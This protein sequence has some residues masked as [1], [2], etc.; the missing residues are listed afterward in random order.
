MPHEPYV[1]TTTPGVFLCRHCGVATVDLDFLKG[2]TRNP[3]LYPREEK[4]KR[5][6][7]AE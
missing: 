1:E 6:E 7:D 2:C 3:P 5:K 4:Y